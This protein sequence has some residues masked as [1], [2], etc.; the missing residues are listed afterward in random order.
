MFNFTYKQYI[1]ILGISWIVFF[2]VFMCLTF[3]E[4]KTLAI[5]AMI[6]MIVIFLWVKRGIYLEE[7]EQQNSKRF[8]ND[9]KY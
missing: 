8:T 2:A 7:K 4:F 3:F 5:I 6:F 9:I 1:R